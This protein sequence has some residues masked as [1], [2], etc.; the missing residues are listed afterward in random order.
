MQLSTVNFRSVD[1]SSYCASKSEMYE[2][3]EE[4]K[5]VKV[6]RIVAKV[7]DGDIEGDWNTIGVVV[8]KLPPKDSVKVSERNMHTHTCTHTHSHTHTHTHTHTC[9]HTH[10][11]YSV[12]HNIPILFHCSLSLYV[13]LCCWPGVLQGDKYS[14]LELS[15]FSSL[16]NV[17]ILFE[18][19]DAH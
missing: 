3:M 13:H 4:S 16:T 7:E 1:S 15:I 19:G 8:D 6:P 9:T 5:M 10:T 17:V 18:F 12:S 11:F 14:I 2:R